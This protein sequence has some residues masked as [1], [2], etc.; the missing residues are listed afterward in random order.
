MVFGMRLWDGFPL[1]AGHLPWPVRGVCNLAVTLLVLAAIGAAGWGITAL[2]GGP[3]CSDYET[4]GPADVC[5][6]P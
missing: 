3:T 1:A 6:D 2:T 4:I 5:L